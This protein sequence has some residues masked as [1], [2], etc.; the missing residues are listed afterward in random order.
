MDSYDTTDDSGRNLTH[1]T[2]DKICIEEN[3]KVTQHDP[4]FENGDVGDDEENLEAPHRP[5]LYVNVTKNNDHI[6]QSEN[7]LEGRTR[8]RIC[9]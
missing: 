7:V 4:D 3:D 8:S 1:Q 9:P 5:I 2:N 6:F